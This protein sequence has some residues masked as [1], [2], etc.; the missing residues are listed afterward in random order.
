MSILFYSSLKNYSIT[1]VNSH[2]VS[3]RWEGTHELFEIVEQI[4]EYTN[5]NSAYVYA[6]FERL[7]RIIPL[8][9]M[10]VKRMPQSTKSKNDEKGNQDA[11]YI[12]NHC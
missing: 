8:M 12:E 5:F 2:Y 10:V 4:S 7:T 3:D 6:I 11:M 9:H 1:G